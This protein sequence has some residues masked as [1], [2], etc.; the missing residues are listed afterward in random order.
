MCCTVPTGPGPISIFFPWGS[1]SGTPGPALRQRACAPVSTSA[2]AQ[3][4]D[5]APHLDQSCPVAARPLHDPILMAPPL[6]LG[7]LPCLAPF[8]K[9]KQSMHGAGADK[10]RRLC[11]RFRLSQ[12]PHSQPPPPKGLNL[13]GNVFLRMNL[14]ISQPCTPK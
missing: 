1:L 10:M 6:F 3:G 7:S 2:L 13:T 11:P 5:R 14:Q 9:R 12:S 4:G 8:P